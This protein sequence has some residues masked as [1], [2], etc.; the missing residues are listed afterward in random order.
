[1][2]YLRSL[3]K[4]RGGRC[5]S[6]TYKNCNTKL[7]WQCKHGHIWDTY[8]YV[9][10]RGSWCPICSNITMSEKYRKYTI[11][12]AKKMAKL[13]G[14]ECLSTEYINNRT[15]MKW[16]CKNGHTWSATYAGILKGD[17]CKKCEGIKQRNTIGMAQELALQRGGKCLSK[18]YKNN[19]TKL[20]WECEFGHKWKAS[21]NSIQRGTWC[22]LCKNK[23]QRHLTKTISQ[24]FGKARI[25]VNYKPKWL[26]NPKTNNRLEIDIFIP[27]L[28]IGIEYNGEQHYKPIRF[29]SISIERAKNRLKYV[30]ALDKIKA[31]EV[32]KNKD[33]IKYFIIFRYDEDLSLDQIITKL[34]N[35]G[36]SRRY[37]KV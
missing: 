6:K 10:R 37:F 11:N 34:T 9:I 36:I 15:Q 14:G 25:K 16:K 5:L 18:I 30:K 23:R 33:K 28:K 22:P 29:G 19:H 7:T 24:I 4:A 31:K 8:Y 13:K 17:W 21:Y 35:A 2:K 20:C 27:Q 12:D 26:K 3:A 1:M 32:L